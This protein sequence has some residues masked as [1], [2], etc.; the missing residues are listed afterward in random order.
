MCFLSK[1]TWATEIVCRNEPGNDRA[2][3]C[4]YDTI[5]QILNRAHAYHI[6]GHVNDKAEV[7]VLGG[8][9]H[10]Y[11]LEYRREFMTLLYKAF[12]IMYD[13]NNRNRAS[14]SMEEEIKLNETARCRVIGLTIETRP[15][16]ITPKTIIEL[17]EMNVTRVQLGIQHTNNRLLTRVQRRCTDEIAINAIKLLKDNGFKVDIH[18]MPDLPKPFTQEFELNNRIKLNSKNLT[19]TINDIDMNFDIVS[20]DDKMFGKVSFILT[21]IA[22]IKLK[23]TH[24]K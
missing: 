10:S 4:G 20:E 6:S 17:R 3:A 11:P 8:T 23:Y 24:V 2:R 18:L 13:T 5:K 22:R 15:D 14:L 19:Y 7:I 12:N 9:W 21:H 1:T 16:Q